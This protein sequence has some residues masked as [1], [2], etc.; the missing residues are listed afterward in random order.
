MFIAAFPQGETDR[1]ER[2]FNPWGLD[3]E[4]IETTLALRHLQ[5]VTKSEEVFPIELYTLNGKVASLEQVKLKLAHAKKHR[6]KERVLSLLAA[7]GVAALIS[8]V[9][10]GAFYLLRGG[11]VTRYAR[12]KSLWAVNL[13]AGG[14][15][16]TTV[17][18][19]RLNQVY[20]DDRGYLDP[21]FSPIAGLV[22]GPLATFS[23]RP[24]RL[25]ARIDQ[26]NSEITDDKLACIN[27]SLKEL[28]GQFTSSYASTIERV[29]AEQAFPHLSGL[30]DELSLSVYMREKAVLDELIKNLETEQPPAPEEA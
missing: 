21:F 16:A 14:V 9:A 26:L 29:N 13:I 3:F 5:S 30:P 18:G 22:V 19:Y 2:S 10:V 17:I 7:L 12:L 1:I 24:K 25:Q 11:S 23:D 28:L 8:G 20:G 15:I 27:V 4:T 6:V